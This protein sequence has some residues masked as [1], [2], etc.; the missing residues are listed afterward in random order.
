MARGQQFHLVDRWSVPLAHEQVFDLLARPSHYGDWW[1]GGAIRCVEADPGEPAV[2]KRA[3]LAV[4]GF[5]PYT[6]TM[7]TESLVVERPSRL[8][9]SS[10]GDLV[11]VGE[12]TIAAGGDGT[13]AVLDWKVSV[14]RRFE[15]LFARALGRVLEANHRWTMDRGR[16]GLVR[17]GPAVLSRVRPGD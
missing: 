16:E 1:D 14:A 3:T 12:W 17:N 5:L 6:L 7:I 4:K 11:G 15:R 2:G 10:T 13:I 9:A 8:V